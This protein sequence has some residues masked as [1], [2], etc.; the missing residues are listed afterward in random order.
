MT[1]T[2]SAVLKA[3][4]LAAFAVIPPIVLPVPLIEMPNRFAAAAVPVALV[5]IQLPTTMLLFPDRLIPEALVALKSLTIRPSIVLPFPLTR[6][7]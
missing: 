7:P 3:I 2:P 4:V 1:C 6:R 5:P